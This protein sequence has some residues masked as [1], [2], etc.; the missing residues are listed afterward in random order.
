MSNYKIINS[1]GFDTLD[2]NFRSSLNCNAK[3]DKEN[4]LKFYYHVIID[5]L[6]DPL[7]S[8]SGD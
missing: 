7:I 1:L 5:K 3:K 8:N 2:K 4:N 6:L